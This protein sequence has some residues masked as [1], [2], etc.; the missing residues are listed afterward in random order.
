MLAI[1]VLAV[2][3]VDVA[4]SVNTAPPVEVT[5][6]TTAAEFIAVADIT[7]ADI[8]GADITTAEITRAAAMSGPP[9]QP[10]PPA[11]LAP[12][13]DGPRC[14]ATPAATTDAG[15][16]ALAMTN[17]GAGGGVG[18]SWVIDARPAAR[19][20]T[21]QPPPLDG[22]P[23]SP[24]NLGGCISGAVTGFLR[25]VVAD[26]LNPMLRL[27][28]DTLLATPNPS[29]L[30]RLVELW[31]G[32][33]EIVLAGYAL[34]VAAAGILLMS[35]HTIQSAYTLRE[36]GPRIV[37]GFCTGALS[38]TGASAAIEATNTITTAVLAGG[39]D[40]AAG[41]DA[42]AQLITSAIATGGTDQ[43]SDGL[44]LVVHGLVVAAVLLA[45]LLSFI[46]RVA[47]TIVLIAGA[48]I[49]LMFH[50]LPHTDGIARWWWRIFAA[51]L[52]I[53]LV[54]SLTLVVGLRVLLS[55]GGLGLFG[56]P[57]DTG[58]ITLLVV[59]ALLYILFK[60]PFW[61]LAAA[62]V[63]HGRTLLGSLVRGFVAYQ[64]FGLLTGRSHRSHR[65]HGR[66]DDD[67]HGG[68]NGGG[69][70]RGGGGGGPRPTPRPHD[71]YP[72]ARPSAGEQLM[73]PLDSLAR[74]GRGPAHPRRRPPVSA[75]AAPGVRGGRPATR[76]PALPLTA[77]G[78]L[79][80]RRPSGGAAAPASPVTG[81]AGAGRGGRG[82]PQLGL[83]PFAGNRPL[84]SGQYPL[85]LE[86]L[87]SRPRRPTPAAPPPPSDARRGAPPGPPGPPTRAGAAWASGAR[88]LPRSGERSGDRAAPTPY[89][90][91]RP[92]RPAP[93]QLGGTAANPPR[94]PAAHPARGAARPA[95]GGLP[96]HDQPDAADG[97]RPGRRHRDG[98]GQHDAREHDTREHDAG[99]YD[100][101][102]HDIRRHDTGQ[103]EPEHHRRPAPPSGDDP[104]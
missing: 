7:V 41:A 62:R 16:G 54:Q 79:S 19:S 25:A 102:Q 17:G 49:A 59:L 72:R 55:P 43:T 27:L 3:S 45:L 67:G 1:V 30:P 8:T 13:C 96:P 69:S 32:S 95:R 88:P 66:A 92:A 75:P 81:R 70:G 58:F 47:L 65:S 42:L 22:Q 5:A 52:A 56:L 78:Q 2:L 73:L 40:E 24:L 71:P 36:L 28:S 29:Q 91:S 98:A 20:S 99:H 90:R 85:P 84:R 103:H 31:T 68:G 35:Y 15:A 33:W 39:V 63:G 57:T 83:D 60:I 10:T 89:P 9:G 51:L 18:E 86:G 101:R 46:V 23:C 37:L 97:R 21:A 64:T 104:S 77:T 44:F 82:Q 34:L 80:A 61:L 6:V 12:T 48:P 53:Q 4:L 74:R 100:A 93:A 87:T 11:P 94:A 50:A 38:L 26:A 76:Q 14:P